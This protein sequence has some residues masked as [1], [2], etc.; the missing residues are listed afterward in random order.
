MARRVGPYELERRLG[1]GGMGEVWAAAHVETGARHALKL[2][3][4]TDAA[5]ALRAARE[6]EALARLDGHPGV[7]RVF[8]AFVDGPRM[9]LAMEL[10]EGG[11]DLEARLA[12]EGP[13]EPAAAARL[14]RDVALAVQH[15]HDR[16]V[17]HRDL[18]PGNVLLDA[19]GAPR[20]VDLGLARLLDGRSLTRTGDVLGTP[21]FLAPEQALGRASDART[22]VFGLGAL[23][24]AALTGRAPR[25]GALLEALARAADQ[26]LPRT[27]VVRPGRARGARRRRRPGDGARAGA[28]ATAGD[29][30]RDLEAWLAGAGLPGRAVARRGPRGRDAARAGR[31]RRR[32]LDRRRPPRGGAR[33]PPPRPSSS[34]SWRRGPGLG[35]PAAPRRSPRTRRR[36]RARPPPSPV[37]SAPGPRRRRA[38]GRARAA[39]SARPRRPWRPT[40]RSARWSRR[41]SPRSGAA[42]P[43]APTRAGSPPRSRRARRPRSPGRPRRAWTSRRCAR[44]PTARR[45][46]AAA[47]LT[48]HLRA[49]AADGR[50]LPG[51]EAAATRE[52]LAAARADVARLVGLQPHARASGADAEV[53][54]AQALDALAG[55]LGPAAVAAV[56]STRLA[57]L[58]DH[59]EEAA[60]LLVERTRR[61]GR[62]EALEHTR[63][64]SAAALGPT[65]RPPPAMRKA[66]ERAAASLAGAGP[67]RRPTELAA[68]LTLDAAWCLVLGGERLEALEHHFEA[69]GWRL[70]GQDDEELEALRHLSLAHRFGHTDLALV[71]WEASPALRRSA[72]MPASMRRPPLRS[73]L[74]AV[75]LV[76][77]PP[78]DLS[79][80]ELDLARVALGLA[81]GARDDFLVTVNEATRLAADGELCA[82]VLRALRA[83]AAGSSAVAEAL[84]DLARAVL[85]RW[86]EGRDAGL[87]APVVGFALNL[88]RER[89]EDVAAR[90]ERL[91]ARLVAEESERPSGLRQDM[92]TIQRAERVD[93]L[94]RAGPGSE[95]LERPDALPEDM[96]ARAFVAAG[97]ASLNL[98]GRGAADRARAWAERA[99]EL[100][101]AVGDGDWTV[102]LEHASRRAYG[103]LTRRLKEAAR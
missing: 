34:R 16:G 42:T 46:R 27:D 35:E 91:I 22:D 102:W 73:R 26:P 6:A 98:G 12:R 86:E 18:K 50:P 45:S 100:A 48:R 74:V 67:D 21:A 41:S 8:S 58:A 14:V 23:L 36:R 55:A 69:G 20:L 88:L 97:H 17:L 33:P 19:A 89:G 43:T 11:E 54:A 4:L 77:N 53:A 39:S 101:R 87:A 10:V 80:A 79:D 103:R 75:A 29:L 40:R 57:A 68:L 1:K 71:D 60:R 15:A 76:L 65:A 38:P 28:H 90:R 24:F 59:A 85:A 61:G 78:G 63:A 52:L 70:P 82:H 83:R 94:R 64:L 49:L 9:V 47:A 31:G 95:A 56:G 37:R 44:L 92:A 51:L 7:L 81:P 32:G 99:E 2:I 5:A 13:L 66:L 96:A 84:P 3:A 30:A 93:D 72:A 62:H 25:Q